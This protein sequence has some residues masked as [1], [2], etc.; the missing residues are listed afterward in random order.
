MKNL[1]ASIYT[2]LL[3]IYRK[4]LFLLKIILNKE[5]FYLLQI[6]LP[7]KFIGSKKYG[8]WFIYDKNI[9]KDSIVY[10]FGIGENIDFDLS[11]IKKYDCKVYAFDPTPKS[12]DWIKYQ[13]LPNH[14]NF[15]E[16]GIEKY[17]GKITFY[18]PKNATHV[19]HSVIPKTN[20]QQN[21]IS[22]PVHTFNTITKKLGH[23]QID[24]LKMDI[25]GSEYNVIDDILM[26][27]IQIKQ[28]LIEFHHRFSGISARQT[29]EA[30]KKFN[31]HGYKI[32]AISPTREEYSF[33]KK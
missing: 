31:N 20:R 24:I 33:I 2:L 13:K 14:F 23:V 21:Q 28:I 5:V 22:V 6:K 18:P 8:G 7:T 32:F 25:E 29:R 19:S 11:I 30:I 16:F 3:I 12:I 1:L 26:S 4:C 27:N 9:N 15:Y 10:S 17:N